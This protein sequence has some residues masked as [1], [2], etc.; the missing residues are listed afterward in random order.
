[1]SF[2]SFPRS[3]ITIRY[4]MLTFRYTRLSGM[5]EKTEYGVCQEIVYFA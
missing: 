5:V 4:A 2:Q 3:F 1:M